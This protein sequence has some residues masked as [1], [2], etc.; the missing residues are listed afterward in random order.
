MAEP[1]DLT[2]NELI[3]FVPEIP[4]FRCF[5]GENIRHRFVHISLQQTVVGAVWYSALFQRCHCV[6]NG[7]LAFRLG[8]FFFFRADVELSDGCENAAA[9][10]SLVSL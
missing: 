5:L 9:V 1:S 7:D 6:S 10:E 2:A 3:A 8:E 4:S